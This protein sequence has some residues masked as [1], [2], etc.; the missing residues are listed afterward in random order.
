MV[1]DLKQVRVQAIE[2]SFLHRRPM[3]LIALGWL[4]SFM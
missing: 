2:P 3:P 1:T 4:L